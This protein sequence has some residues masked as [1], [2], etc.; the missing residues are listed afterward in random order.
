MLTEFGKF[1]RKLRIDRN[2]LLKDMSEKL[3]ITVA[4]LSAVENG[5][6][7]VPDN[8]LNKIKELYNLSD[9]E[10]IVM[11]DA[12]YEDKNTISFPIKNSEDKNFL[13]SF[14][15]EFDNLSNDEKQDI[16]NIFNSKRK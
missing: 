8:W 7:D 9:D 5:K 13:L 15:R 1:L 14:A 4:Y 6:R 16:I 3:N 11:Q 12:A 10:Y 2:E